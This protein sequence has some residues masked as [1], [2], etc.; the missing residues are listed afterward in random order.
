MKSEKSAQLNVGKDTRKGFP[1]EI[2]GFTG[3]GKLI[4]H[5]T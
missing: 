3:T 2:I 4:P 5:E 1:A